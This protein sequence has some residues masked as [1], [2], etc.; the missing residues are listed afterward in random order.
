VI[1][2]NAVGNVDKLKLEFSDELGILYNDVVLSDFIEIYR[3]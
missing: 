2:Y 3:L 1:V